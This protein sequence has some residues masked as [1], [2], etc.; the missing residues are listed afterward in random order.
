MF[1]GR[2]ACCPALG[3]GA[4]AVG[5]MLPLWEPTGK[6]ASLTGLFRGFSGRGGVSGE[7]IAL[8]SA[9]QEPTEL[10]P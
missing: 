2:A 5:Q 8:K 6:G 10:W 9:G 4:D 1:L 3:C 7:Q